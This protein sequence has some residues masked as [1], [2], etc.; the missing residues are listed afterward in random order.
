MGDCVLTHTADDPSSAQARVPAQ[1]SSVSQVEPGR[2]SSS[3]VPSQSSSCP[4]QSSSA[5]A[6]WTVLFPSWQSPASDTAPEGCVQARTTCSA[7]P[8]P[9]PSAST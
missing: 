1:P 8:Y 2:K 7:L 5:R 9:S 6:G 3:A 4:S